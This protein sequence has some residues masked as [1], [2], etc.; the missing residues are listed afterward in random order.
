MRGELRQSSRFLGW[1]IA[2]LLQHK[3]HIMTDQWWL[4]VPGAVH[5]HHGR[6]GET[7]VIALANGHEVSVARS[8]LTYGNKSGE[9]LW[10]MLEFAGPDAVGDPHGWLDPADVLDHLHTLHGIS[11][12]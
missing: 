8:P 7:V 2:D 5:T 3:E 6:L 4:T 12:R 1:H 10:E 9:G 11:T